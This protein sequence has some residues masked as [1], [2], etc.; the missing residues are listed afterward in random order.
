MLC[1]SSGHEQAEAEGR[2]HFFPLIILTSTIRVNSVYHLAFHAH[3]YTQRLTLTAPCQL[4][5]DPPCVYEQ[6]KYVASTTCLLALGS[7]DVTRI[8]EDYIIYNASSRLKPLEHE[9]P[10]LNLYYP[11][12][13]KLLFFLQCTSLSYVERLSLRKIWLVVSNTRLTL[14][15]KPSV[16]GSSG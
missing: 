9:Y 14:H 6:N 3:V 12:E 15:L 16:T 2:P 11:T 5:L 7:Q 8:K 1:A 10:F 13:Q 4:H